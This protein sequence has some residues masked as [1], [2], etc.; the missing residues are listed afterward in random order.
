MKTL[1]FFLVGFRPPPPTRSPPAPPA[2]IGDRWRVNAVSL[3]TKTAAKNNI[4]D[5]SQEQPSH[6]WEVHQPVVSRTMAPPRR[7]LIATV[8]EPC[9]PKQSFMN[10]RNSALIEN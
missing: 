6:E 1:G 9:D 2:D 4:N 8:C 5:L 7:H 10:K 3:H